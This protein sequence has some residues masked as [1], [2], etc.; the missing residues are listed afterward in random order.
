MASVDGRK[1]LDHS[2]HTF[3]AGLQ[4]SLA[5]FLLWM[6]CTIIKHVMVLKDE[7]NIL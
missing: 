1:N 6:L 3:S 5:F 2:P 7:T 4:G